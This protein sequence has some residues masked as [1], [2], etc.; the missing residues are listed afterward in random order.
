MLNATATLGFV[1]HRGTHIIMALHQLQPVQISS[2]THIIYHT[3][4]A[5]VL[6][7]SWEGKH[8]LHGCLHMAMR[9]GLSGLLSVAQCSVT[10]VMI[11]APNIMKETFTRLFQDCTSAGS[12][13]QG[14]PMPQHSLLHVHQIHRQ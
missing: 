4:R 13:V 8:G 3:M 9:V 1:H 6:F 7:C 10:N 11:C 5:T 14:T 12:C 2:I